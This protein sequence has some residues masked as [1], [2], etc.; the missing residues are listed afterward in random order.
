MPALPYIQAT[1][2]EIQRVARVAPLSIPHST[3]RTTSV[4]EFTF[5]K[6]SVF[7]ANISF[8][9]NDPKYFENPQV[10]NPLRFITTD[11]K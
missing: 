6:N 2:A 10:F 11:G 3:M 8:I 1:I 5:P 9:M 7:F 4:N